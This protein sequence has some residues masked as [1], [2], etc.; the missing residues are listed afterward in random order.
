[1][2]IDS[3]L[4][5]TQQLIYGSDMTSAHWMENSK[6]HSGYFMNHADLIIPQFAKPVAW[7]EISQIGKR[8]PS[9]YFLTIH[10]IYGARSR[11]IRKVKISLSN[12]KK[13]NVSRIKSILMEYQ[14]ILEGYTICTKID[15]YLSSKENR[16]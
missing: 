16:N 6:E 11:E 5:M 9:G 13:T 10:R 4:W 3:L 1:M 8:N 14:D 2:R 15:R 7:I 12:P